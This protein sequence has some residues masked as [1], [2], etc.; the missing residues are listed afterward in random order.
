MDFLYFKDELPYKEGVVSENVVTRFQQSLYGFKPHAIQRAIDLGYKKIIWLDPSVLPITDMKY[1]IDELDTNPLLIVEGDAKIVDMCNQKALNWFGFNTEDLKDVKHLG[2]TI[3]CF[4]FNDEKTMEV[5]NLWKKA[6]EE[7]IYGTQDEF[8]LGHWAD[9][10]CMALAIHKVGVK[11][12]G[13]KE[14]KYIN[15]KTI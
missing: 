2:G 5:F 13:I 11:R 15:Q 1:L 9:E 4:N 7:G 6:E 14:F 8:M 3:Y 12:N 10:T